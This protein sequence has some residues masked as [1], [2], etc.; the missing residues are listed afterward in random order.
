MSDV[1]RIKVTV[2]TIFKDGG[3]REV[4]FNM[5]P[6]RFQMSQDREV[7]P[8][9]DDSD[10]KNFGRPVAMEVDPNRRGTRLMINGFIEASKG[11]EWP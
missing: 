10:P 2:E 6:F 1:E 5:D 4:I 11:K 8:V 3:R 9:Y 7:R